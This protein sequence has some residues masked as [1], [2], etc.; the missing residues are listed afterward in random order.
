MASRRSSIAKVTPPQVHDAVSRRRLFRL[1]D[2][3]PEDKLIW[4]VGPPGAGK[5]TLVATWLKDRN[6]PSAWYQVD[7]TD[8]DLA[9]F[10]FYFRAA[11]DGI[12]TSRKVSL[13]LFTP[14]YGHDAAGFARRFFRT[15]AA[16]ARLGTVLVLDNLHEIDAHAALHQTVVAAHDE[17]RNRLRIVVISRAPPPPAYSRLVMHGSIRMLSWPDL[18]LTAEDAAALAERKASISPETVTRMLRAAGGWAAGFV[19]ALERLG[20]VPDAP[21]L[22]HATDE[23]V[24]DYFATQI[25][26]RLEPELQ[27]FL[28]M[29]SLLPQM[30]A[31]ACESLTGCARA[32][33]FL[34]TMFRRQLFTDRRSGTSPQFAFHALFRQFLL[35]CL[36]RRFD[37]EAVNLLQVRAAELLELANEVE[38]AFKLRCAAADWCGAAAMLV[39][40]APALLAQGR[41]RTFEEWASA[42]PVKIRDESAD[43]KYWTGIANLPLKPTEARQILECAHGSYLA[44]GDRSSALLAASAVAQG[45]YLEAAEFKDLR[46]WLY[47]M[48]SAL[49]AGVVLRSAEAELQVYSGLLIAVIFGEP[50]DPIAE[51]CAR[52]IVQLI[53]A[54]GDPNQ[55]I[56]AAAITMLFCLYTGEFRL[57]RSLEKQVE[58]Y[59][60]A[61]ELTALNA[62]LW[63]CYLAYLSVAEHTIERG[64]V[65]VARAEEIAER[66]GFGYVLTTAYSGRSALMRVGDVDRWLALAAPSKETSRPYDTAHYLGNSLYRAAD[67]GDWRRAVEFIEPTMRY[68]DHTG[69]AYQRLIWEVPSAWALAELGE[70][71]EARRHIAVSEALLAT[72]NAA[73]YRARV[74]LGRANVERCAGR[75]HDYLIALRDGFGAAARDYAAGRYA[76]WVPTAGA[77]RVCA[78]ALAHDIEP[79]FVRAYI[80]EY[81]IS[82]PED[83]PEAWPWRVRVYTLG[84]IRQD[85]VSRLGGM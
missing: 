57:A 18:Q 74:S 65:A 38:P 28:M 24:F 79:E 46:Y 80:R 27:E 69:T 59:L 41:H 85:V 17:L 13:P 40:N 29:V 63:Y 61:A 2:D 5:T 83:A 54:N 56:L 7:P 30:T 77:P 34:D 64:F 4:I 75:E 35:N 12:A 45:M 16:R 47:E 58:P 8:Q 82:P 62:A 39:R 36:H 71:E 1:L 14:E 43:L 55:K 15:V 66:E 76:F 78:D 26:D 70:G 52:R 53:D 60:A 10:Y 21:G 25:F 6:A 72:T 44:S 67:R 48:K 33:E 37:V 50:G 23:I 81:P 19:L 11:V 31:G 32:G 20:D 3:T 73:C 42:L 51:R 49:D 9:G 68:L 22:G 84:V